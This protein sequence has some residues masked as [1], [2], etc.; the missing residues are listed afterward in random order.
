MNKL[1]RRTFI[2]GL[3]AVAAMPAR[4]EGTWPI[5]P[6]TLVH[7]FPPGGPV[8]TLSRILADPLSKRLGQQIIVEARP[9]ATGTTAA[10]QVARAAPDGYTLTAIPATFPTS[11]AI[12]RALPYRPLDDFTFISTTAEYPLVIVTRADHPI[13]TLPGLISQAQSQK[14]P[15]QYATAG[16]GS[17]Q[18][19]TMELFAKMADIRLQHIPY[20]GG[21]PA[22]VDLLGKQVDL[23]IDPPTAL[24]KL[25]EDGK[26]RPL[27]VSSAERFFGLPSVPTV[28]EAGFPEFAVTAYQGL[29]GPAGLPP[30]LVERL[31]G[32]LA[33]VL[34]DKTVIEQL[35]K[36]GNY[37]RPSSTEEFKARLAGDITRWTKVVAEANIERI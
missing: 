4:S 36:V 15:L 7:G 10:G 26:L 28:A 23:L 18:H 9:G 34:A 24:V 31:N 8:D 13:R 6:I 33:A 20:R 27:A 14:T 1:T 11:A 2:V 25:I 3:S 29:A 37:P 35:R 30:A 12:F 19:L 5:R 17:I 32:D 16:A 21:A 22:I